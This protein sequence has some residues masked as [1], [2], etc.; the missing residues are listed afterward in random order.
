MHLTKTDYLEYTF[1]RKNLW[2]KKHKPELFKDLELS[3]FE[4]KIIEEGNIA[5]ETARNLFQG[6]KLIDIVG[7]NAVPVTQEFLDK[8][9]TTLFQGAFL[10]DGFNLCYYCM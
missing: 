8:N 4:K 3:E 9:V 10:F 7:V 6:G 2:L 5:D 1:C